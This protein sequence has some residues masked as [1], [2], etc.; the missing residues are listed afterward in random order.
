MIINFRWFLLLFVT[1][2]WVFH[3]NN[4]HDFSRLF[5][6]FVVLLAKEFS[7]D[8]KQTQNAGAQLQTGE[9]YLAL[10]SSA[11]RSCKFGMSS[12]VRKLIFAG[13]SFIHSSE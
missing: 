12:T 7:T 3:R 6:H 4:D 10:S 2:V 5:F 11:P 13:I 9:P 8:S 1:I